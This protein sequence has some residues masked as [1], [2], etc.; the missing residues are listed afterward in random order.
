MSDT[1]EENSRHQLIELFFDPG[2]KLLNFIK[3]ARPSTPVGLAELFGGA[4]AVAFGS[5]PLKIA[6]L[7]AMIHGSTIFEVE[8]DMES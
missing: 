6:G 7:T 5:I 3:E 8:V 4:L 2:E 1:V